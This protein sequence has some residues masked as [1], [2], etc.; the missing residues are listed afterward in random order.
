M[1]NNFTLSKKFFLNRIFYFLLSIL[2]L[3]IFS[4]CATIPKESVELNQAVKQ[5]I[6]NQQKAY[7]HLFNAYFINKK[8]K[9]DNW[10][11]DVYAPTFIKNF[12]ALMSK[13]G[14]AD[15]NNESSYIIIN[16]IIEKRDSMQAD[17]GNVK[18]IIW[19]KISQDQ[20]L[21]L[22]ANEQIS[23]LLKSSLNVQES[24]KSLLN[25]S[26]KISGVNFN[27]QNFENIFNQYLNNLNS[28]TNKYI[29]LINDIQP[30]IN[31]E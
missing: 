31:G 10:I 1:K 28:S 24:T 25:N 12:N 26:S 11:I 8:E 14:I 7:Q 17:L 3:F 22:D 6:I 21:L 18:T 16:K 9:I 30:L 20:S 4:N 27:F 15:T 13:E 2:P 23:Q 29:P 19:Q 5:G